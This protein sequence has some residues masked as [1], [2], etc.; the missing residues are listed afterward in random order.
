MDRQSE[1]PAEARSDGKTNQADP[2]QRSGRTAGF[3]R[4]AR[5]LRNRRAGFAPV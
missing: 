1:A 2:M 4:M 3:S 5:R